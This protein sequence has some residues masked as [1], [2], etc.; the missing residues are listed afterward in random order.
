M[1]LPTTFSFS[2]CDVRL[3][4]LHDIQSG[5]QILLNHAR[6]NNQYAADQCFRWLERRWGLRCQDVLVE[7]LAALLHFLLFSRLDHIRNDNAWFLHDL[8]LK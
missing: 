5:I 6:N 7:D 4:E 3:S 8:L 2:F 1:V